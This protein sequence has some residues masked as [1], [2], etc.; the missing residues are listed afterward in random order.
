MKDA[1]AEAAVHVALERYSKRYDA[2][3]GIGAAGDGPTPEEVSE[4]HDELNAILDEELAAAFAAAEKLRGG[5]VSVPE[6]EGAS[7]EVKDLSKLLTLAAECE[8]SGQSRRAESLHQARIP[9]YVG[10]IEQQ[11]SLAV[12]SCGA[13]SHAVSRLPYYSVFPRS[14]EFS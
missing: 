8:Q 9:Y 13:C 12:I 1:L 4:L 10:S 2:G 5:G 14:A 7:S 11:L 3:V 6:A